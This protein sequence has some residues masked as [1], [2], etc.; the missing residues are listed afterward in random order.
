LRVGLTGSEVRVD[1]PIVLFDGVCNFC[2]RSVNFI[3][4]HDTRRRFR[5]AALQSDAGQ[6]V[7]RRFALRTDDFDTAVL[8]ERGRA[9][10]KSAAALRIARNLGGWW[11]LLA[12]LFAIPPFLR[13]AAYDVLARNRYRW[14]GKADSCRVPTPEV[15]ERFLH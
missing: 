7:L 15:W 11:S 3:L 10:T 5:F 13:D 4:D 12:L 14:F 9:Y 8:V 1:G 2:N 6:A